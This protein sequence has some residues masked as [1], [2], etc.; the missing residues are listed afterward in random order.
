MG[1]L[2][3]LVFAVLIVAV[4]IGFFM[5]YRIRDGRIVDPS[6]VVATPGQLGHV[7][8]DKAREA[9]ATIGDKVAVGA[10]AAQH[11]LS[12][13]ALTGKIKAKITLDDTLKGSSVGVDSNDGAVTLTGTVTSAAQHTRV[14]Q[15]T[16]ETDG[17]KSVA[18][19]LVVQ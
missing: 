4:V 7:D 14:L 15:L 2:L 12:N 13:A 6:G 16:K 17:V 3:R 9:G 19:H 10:N 8:T 18:D 1:A 5:G 11:A